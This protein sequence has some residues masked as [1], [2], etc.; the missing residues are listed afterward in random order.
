MEKAKKDLGGVVQG[1]YRDGLEKDV[2]IRASRLGLGYSDLRKANIPSD[3]LSF[4]SREEAIE[5]KSI[6]LRSASRRLY[7]GLV[8]PEK[9]LDLLV[10]SLRNDYR[11]K[12]I[13]RVL[14][15]EPAYLDWL[16]K[17]NIIKKMPPLSQ[18]EDHIDLSG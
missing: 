12:D 8:D 14:I 17:Y 10:E 18:E 7:L 6:P 2:R 16:S 4:V 15:S 1:L 9:K 11:F 13:I 3:V 5:Y